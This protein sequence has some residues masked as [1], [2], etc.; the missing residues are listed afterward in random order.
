MKKHSEYNEQRPLTW[1]KSEIKF[2]I[3]KTNA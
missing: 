2:I 1:G 3:N